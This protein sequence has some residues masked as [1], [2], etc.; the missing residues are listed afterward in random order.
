MDPL[1]VHDRG[2]GKKKVFYEYLMTGHKMFQIVK[3]KHKEN[4]AKEAKAQ[5]K[6]QCVKTALA[7]LRQEQRKAKRKLPPKKI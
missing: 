4:V 3:E 6:E 1:P 5:K 7:K 2:K